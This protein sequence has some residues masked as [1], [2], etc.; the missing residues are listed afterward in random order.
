M[1]DKY[2][3]SLSLEWYNKQ[4]AILVKDEN[5]TKATDIPAPKMNWINKDDALFYEIVDEEGRGLKPYWVNNNDIRV[6]ESRP[7]H[8]IKGWRADMVSKPGTLEGF[9]EKISLKEIKNEEAEIKNILIKGDN[10]LALNSLKQLLSTKSEIE[11]VKTAYLDVPY[12]TDSSFQHYDDSLEHSEW[13]TMMRDRMLL[14]WELLRDDGCL[15]V[16]LDDKESS[17]CKVMLDEIFGRN[18]YCNQ[19]VIS[20]NKPFGFKGTSK[21]LFKQAN[22]ILFYAKNKEVFTQKKIFIEKGYDTAYNMVFKDMTLPEKKWEWIK[23][24]DAVAIEKGYKDAKEAREKLSKEEMEDEIAQFALRNAERVFQTAAAG[25]GAFLKRKETI[26]YSKEN[27]NKIVRHPNDDMDYM[28]I[29]G[30]RVIFYKERIVN[31]NGLMIPGEIITDMWDDISFEGLAHE[32]GIDFPKSKKPEK[33]IQRIIDISSEP[34][35]LVLDVFAGSGT[36]LAV[37]HKMNRR[38]IGVE[39]GKHAES[40]II[41]RL[42]SVIDGSDQ[43]GISKTENW[44]GGG[45]FKYYK[46]GQSIISLKKDNSIDFNWQLGKSFIEQSL[47]LSYDYEMIN[48]FN[49]NE[50]KLFKDDSETPKIGIQKIGNKVRIAI[51]TLCPP[52]SDSIM[53]KY[54]ELHGMYKKVMDKY[55]PEFINVFTNKGVEIAFETKPEKLEVI[56]VPT[57]IYSAND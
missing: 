36:T 35:D 38:W 15:F 42:K 27:K 55:K 25:G 5:N 51:V 19:I 10:L 2:T 21:D 37:A 57:A 43:S 23:I 44:K 39:L 9:D 13:L 26:E 1:K 28:F 11:K 33:L 56:K 3:G 34:G 14:V 29:G 18:N 41:P 16:H 40:L 52:D 32:G 47:L 8:F 17:Y 20:T 24:Q 22:H 4:K 49:F 48:D 46:L 50:G 30:R 7:M 31:I 6:K 54:D 12:N 45:S 53:L